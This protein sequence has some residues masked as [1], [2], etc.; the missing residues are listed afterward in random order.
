M[1]IIRFIGGLGNQMFQYALYEKYKSLGCEVYADLSAYEKSGMEYQLDIFGIHVTQAQKKDIRRLSG[2]GMDL[3]SRIARKLGMKKSTYC[4]EDPEVHYEPWI[5]DLKE[6]YLD[7]YWQTE[8]YFSDIRSL[9]LEKFV[10]PKSSRP[11][12]EKALERIQNTE[13][14]SIHIR[15][16]DYLSGREFELYGGICSLKYYEKAAAYFRSKLQSPVFFVFSDDIPWVRNHLKLE[17]AV[18]ADWNNGTEDFY[19]MYLMMNCRHNILANSSFSWWAAWLNQNLEKEVLA[20]SRWFNLHLAPDIIC[21]DW[22]KAE[23]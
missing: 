2:N 22:R 11:E 6:A 13:S 15:R 18:Y 16:G 9:L 19:D 7:G 8:K 3:R 20:P 12:N 10:F 17:N 23:L 14:V 4:V 1:I 21:Q 5:L